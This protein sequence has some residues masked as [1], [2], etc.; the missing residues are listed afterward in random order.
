MSRFNCTDCVKDGT[1]A[2]PFGANK[3]HDYSSD[4]DNLLV[5]EN[6]AYEKAIDDFVSYANTMPT[7]E[8]DGEIRPMWLEEIAEQLKRGNS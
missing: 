5:D 4:C 7:V 6:H 2:C 3:R 8:N 1:D